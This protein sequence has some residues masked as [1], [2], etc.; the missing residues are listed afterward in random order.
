MTQKKPFENMVQTFYGLRNVGVFIES[1]AQTNFLAKEKVWFRFVNV[2]LPMGLVP[3]S[4]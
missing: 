2:V 4:V 3:I 1:K